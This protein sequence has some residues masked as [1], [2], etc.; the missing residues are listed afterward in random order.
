MEGSKEEQWDHG[1][2]VRKLAELQRLRLVASNAQA[3]LKAFEEEV[4]VWAKKA[5]EH[6]QKTIAEMDRW[7]PSSNE[8]YR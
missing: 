8:L 2:M 4:R 7:F 1:V 6:A 5:K 3:D